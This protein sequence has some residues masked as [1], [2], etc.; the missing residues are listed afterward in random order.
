MFLFF[1][2]QAAVAMEIL[3]LIILSPIV[4]CE[5]NLSTVQEASL[6]AVCLCVCV[7]VRACV[8]VILLKGINIPIIL[9]GVHRVLFW[10]QFLEI[11]H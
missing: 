8:C 11:I 4:K 3:L 6:T 7:C 2:E 1:S 5:W 9:G 10:L